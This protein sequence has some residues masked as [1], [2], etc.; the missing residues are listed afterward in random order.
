[1]IGNLANEVVV[2][3]LNKH[4]YLITISLCSISKVKYAV[5]F[6]VLDFFYFIDKHCR[7]PPTCSFQKNEMNRRNRKCNT[8]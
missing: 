5:F 6:C 4:I 8:K 3:E 7:G 2:A 1:M